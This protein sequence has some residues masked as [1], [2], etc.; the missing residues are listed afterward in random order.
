QYGD[1]N[2]II[3]NQDS[4]YQ[5]FGGDN[6]AEANQGDATVTSER[7]FSQQIQSGGYNN[8]YSTQ[9][10]S[11]NS[12]FQEQNG[13]LNTAEVHQNTSS[14]GGDNY[15]EQYQLGGLNEAYIEQDGQNHSANQEQYGIFN[16][17]VVIQNG[18]QVSG[19]QSLSIQRGMNND[20]YI[21]QMAN[22]NIAD[23]DQLGMNHQSVINQNSL[24]TSA[25][26]GG[27]NTAI[28]TQ[29]N[30]NVSLTRQTQRT[31]A[32]KAHTF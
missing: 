1:D 4:D 19:N 17:S 10:G 24:G 8:A 27:S 22:G 14:T 29:R 23:V 3:Q 2:E 16:E 21:N 31:A 6:Y 7:A 18:G 30:A 11:D 20:S 25:G 32:T 12:S 9:Y 5:P 28:V 13:L 15:A 26:T